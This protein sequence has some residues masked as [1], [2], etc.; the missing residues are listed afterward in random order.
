MARYVDAGRLTI[1]HGSEIDTVICG[2][3]PAGGRVVWMW[4]YV[5]AIVVSQRKKSNLPPR[6]MRSLHDVMYRPKGVLEKM[7]HE[8]KILFIVGISTTRI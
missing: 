3:I 5:A 6:C 2:C 8:T 7:R 1:E 4:R